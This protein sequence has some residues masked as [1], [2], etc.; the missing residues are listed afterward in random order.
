[1]QNP[2]EYAF[3]NGVQL[4]SLED[5]KLLQDYCKE[6]LGWC[7]Q[8]IQ[9]LINYYMD[10][11]E[12]HA[13]IVSLWI[14]GTYFHDKFSTYPFLFI[15]AMRGSGK[16]RLLKI[17]SSISKG[18]FGYV[19][20]GITEAV[21]FRMP[22]G[23]TLCLDEAES[24]GSKEK[25]FLREYFNACY[26]KGGI[27]KRTKKVK[28]KD[29]EGF[30][31][32]TFEPYK[33]IAMANI[34]GMEEVLGD[35]CVTIVLEKS[36]NSVK[37]KK[38]E[39]FDDNSRFFELK[40]TLQKISVVMQC[41]YHE[42]QL[43]NLWNDYVNRTYTSNYITTY[44]TLTT[45][46]YITTLEENRENTKKKLQ[47]FDLDEFFQKIDETN[48]NGRNLELF[49]PLFQI[50]RSLSIEDFEETIKISK[51][52]VNLKKEDEFADSKDVEVYDFIA[53]M[54]EDVGFIK[55]KDLV[56]Q[57]KIFSGETEDWIN[58]RWLGRA[59]KRL[60]LIIDKK[61]MSSGIFVIVDIK[62][63]KEKLK[64]FKKGEVKDETKV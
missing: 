15:N 13:K 53:S 44:I 57:F 3:E 19:Q 50:A 49:F 5:S 63:A 6:K 17:I 23:Q 40:R 38:Q 12:H 21:L 32:E 41:S 28:D 31:L 2:I 25:A 10:I 26:K 34:W 14:I 42:K 59:L 64:I 33:P 27:V 47:E 1:M 48:I 8:E 20:T 29:G 7:Y 60:N 9:D 11:Q 56:Y 36:D 62:K 58:D 55:V 46:N 37:T 4:T 24:M 39:N 61:R 52:I 54:K 35:R 51:A 30:S 22:K 16:T 45:Q 18:G 43:I